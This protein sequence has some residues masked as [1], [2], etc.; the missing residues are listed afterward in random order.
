MWSGVN[1]ENM[2]CQ[3]S[4]LSLDNN[5]ELKDQAILTP[6]SRKWSHED[7][8]KVNA[9]GHNS[10]YAPYMPTNDCHFITPSV[11]KWSTAQDSQIQ[12]APH[13][14]NNS[15]KPHQQLYSHQSL[16]GRQIFAQL[17]PHLTQSRRKGPNMTCTEAEIQQLNQQIESQQRIYAQLYQKLMSGEL[18]QSSNAQQNDFNSLSR[19]ATFER[20]SSSS[21]TNQIIEEFE[22]CLNQCDEQYR[23]LEK[24]R[25]KTEAELVKP[26]L[27]LG[28]SSSNQLQIPRLPPTPTRIDRLIVDFFREHARVVTLLSRMEELR[29]VEFDENLRAVMIEWLDAIRLLQQRRLNE[30]NAILNAVSNRINRVAVYYNEDKG[31]FYVLILLIFQ[32]LELISQTEALM[33]LT[34]AT[35]RARN[36]NWCALI[37]T[38]KPDSPIQQEQ[39]ETIQLLD[40]RCEPP[41]IPCRSLKT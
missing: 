25:K 9:I 39:L 26:N 37:L 13:V 24:A 18:K 33:I 5:N 6:S 2:I 21:S 27:G 15:V 3:M 12:Y 35:I 28:I 34:Q 41:E 31:R 23:E 8:P 20:Q 11:G 40:Y 30:R 32:L 4:K 19:P 17:N 22:T 36:A 7:S 16:P 10:V 38:I 1:N 29:K 14:T